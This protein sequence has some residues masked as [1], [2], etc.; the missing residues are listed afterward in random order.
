M[1]NEYIQTLHV[2][3]GEKWYASNQIGEEL[4]QTLS[5]TQRRTQSAAERCGDIHYGNLA[6][7]AGGGRAAEGGKEEFGEKWIRG[8]GRWKV[9]EGGKLGRNEGRKRGTAVMQEYGEGGEAGREK[10][11]YVCY[12]GK[13][14]RTAGDGE[15]K[16]VEEWSGARVGQ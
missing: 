8:K 6:H 2:K 16:G 7:H 4:T 9:C 13:R 15:G 10:C 11:R 12:G 1:E 5:Q 3:W 14:G